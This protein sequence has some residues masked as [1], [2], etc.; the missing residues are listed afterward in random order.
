MKPVLVPIPQD[1]LEETKNIWWPYVVS[2]A[3]R[4][5]CEPDDKAGMLFRGEVQ[6]CIIWDDDAKKAMALLGLQYV[7][8]SKDR[9]G[10]LVWLTGENRAAWAHLFADLQTYLRDH[11]KCKAVRAVARQGWAKHLLANGFRET[12]R[13]FDKEL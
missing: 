4:D 11:Q 7:M 9:M 2:I 5:H 6:A 3:E 10:Q 12:H 8:R 1:N 13:I